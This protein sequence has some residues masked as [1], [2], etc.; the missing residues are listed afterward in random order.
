M[1]SF[2]SR[3]KEKLENV[4]KIAYHIITKENS[5]KSVSKMSLDVDQ[6]RTKN[7]DEDLQQHSS[8]RKQDTLDLASTVLSQSGFLRK[9]GTFIRSLSDI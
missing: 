8:F 5:F 2:R 9:V 6:N 3:A 4:K 1:N 7:V